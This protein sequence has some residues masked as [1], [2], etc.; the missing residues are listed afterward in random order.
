VRDG[1]LAEHAPRD[2]DVLIVGCGNSQLSE[3][4]ATRG[5]D[6]ARVVSVDFSAQS[7]EQAA[8]RARERASRDE[9]LGALRYCVADCRSLHE[10]FPPSSFDCAVDKGA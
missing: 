5:W 9:R 8:G 4:L 1:T 2:A 7:I 6:P 10:S 3:E